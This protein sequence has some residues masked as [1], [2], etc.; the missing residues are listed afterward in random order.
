[1]S[2]LTRLEG[3]SAV[4][5]AMLTAPSLCL[6]LYSCEKL[7]RRV[8]SA[9]IS[10]EKACIYKVEESVR[11]SD[12]D[13]TRDICIHRHVILFSAMLQI[14]MSCLT[15]LSVP[16]TA[17]SHTMHTASPFR[18]INISPR[19]ELSSSLLRRRNARPRECGISHRC[20]SP[21][22]RQEPSDPNPSCVS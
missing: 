7:Y 3:G 18:A 6:V 10:T 12:L 11:S 5:E 9:L 21:S 22:T 20:S 8:V 16:S 2:Y 15:S 19:Q 14:A 17:E 4:E 1:M 13:G